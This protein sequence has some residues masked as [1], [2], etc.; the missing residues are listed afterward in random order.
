MQSASPAT[1]TAAASDAAARARKIA[2]VLGGAWIVVALLSTFFGSGGL[3]RAW[4]SMQEGG[5]L[6]W[7]LLLGGL[8]ALG[9]TYGYGV[10]G[11]GQP[12]WPAWPPLLLALAFPLLAWLGVT[13]AMYMAEEAIASA[14]LDPL[15]KN[16]LVAA[17]LSEA[18]NLSRLGSWIACVVSALAALSVGARATARVPAVALRGRAVL[19]ALVGAG[20]ALALSAWP[21]VIW[22]VSPE[23]IVSAPLAATLCG[24]V[25]TAI[26]TAALVGEPT[27]GDDARD[28]AA[29]DALVAAASGGAACVLG[30]LS[31]GLGGMIRAFGAISAKSIDPSLKATILA[32]GLEEA[33]MAALVGASML[34]PL[35]FGAVVAAT[36]RSGGAGRAFRHA[37]VGILVA[38]LVSVAAAG[39]LLPPATAG[40]RRFG[41][42]GEQ[43]A[44]P[45]AAVRVHEGGLGT[46]GGCRRPRVHEPRA[47]WHPQRAPRPGNE[48][49]TTLL[50]GCNLHNSSRCHANPCGA[51][52]A[53]RR[54]VVAPSIPRSSAAAC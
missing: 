23:A 36:A 40:L 49:G 38:V 43:R 34:L 29:G 9:V 33:R 26:A 46:N 44:H 13:A 21:M 8:L 52:G 16:T 1:A 19:V 41:P 22:G 45:V 48:R 10:L 27:A 24:V 42:K 11:A 2:L 25:G 50:A 12:R 31:S 28:L 7:A 3:H 32:A 54:S 15:Q 30:A 6:M 20:G 47:T 18:L 14:S 37:R 51:P 4:E 5:S 17:A 39:L 53:S 35:A